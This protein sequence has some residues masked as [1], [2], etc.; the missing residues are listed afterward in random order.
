MQRGYEVVLQRYVAAWLMAR[1]D[2]LEMVDTYMQMLDPHQVG[3]SLQGDGA[4]DI[5]RSVL[6]IERDPVSYGFVVHGTLLS[7]LSQE[8]Q[9]DPYLAHTQFELEH[10]KDVLQVL[11]Q[12]MAKRPWWK[13]NLPAIR[14][15]RRILKAVK[16]THES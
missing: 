11:G 6:K 3:Q 8:A 13:T 14:K 7:Q 5:A 16:D 10:G 9:K 2:V 12:T 15:A 4:V 1:S